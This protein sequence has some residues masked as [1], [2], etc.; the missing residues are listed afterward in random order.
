MATELSGKIPWAAVAGAAVLMTLLPGGSCLPVLSEAL[1][2]DDATGDDDD[3]TG[4]DDDTTGDDD[5]TTGDDDDTTGDDDTTPD[6]VPRIEIHATSDI[7]HTYYRYE[8]DVACTSEPGEWT[9]SAHH[10]D[11]PEDLV[12]MGVH[13]DPVAGGQHTEAFFFYWR[14]GGGEIEVPAGGLTCSLNFSATEPRV[15]GRFSC[16]DQVVVYGDVEEPVQ[17]HLSGFLC[18]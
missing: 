18:P 9:F 3:A 17:I 4:D 5:D 11:A 1:P 8:G 14:V 10:A 6:L 15:Q 12:E 13:A 2:D 7:L 16:A